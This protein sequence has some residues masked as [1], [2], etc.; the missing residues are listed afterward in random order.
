MTG[1]GGGGVRGK[2]E[3]WERANEPTNERKKTN[4]QTKQWVL[5]SSAGN[6]ALF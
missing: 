6:L 5:V 1:Q 4:K 3:E 2:H